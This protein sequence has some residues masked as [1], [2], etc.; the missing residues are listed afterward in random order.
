MMD[1]R[2]VQLQ[3]FTNFL[4]KIFLIEP[5]QQELIL[6]TKN[7]VQ[8]YINSLNSKKIISN[9]KHS[10][11]IENNWGADLADI[12]LISKFD[13]IIS[14]LLFIFDIYSKYALVLPLKDKKKVIQLLVLFRKFQMSLIAN[15]AKY[16]QTRAANFIIDQ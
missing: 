9:G 2:E 10:F 14:F 8:T 5:K 7:Q 1:I 16:G 11:F 3:W 4:I 6:K 15:Q 13:K 12:Q